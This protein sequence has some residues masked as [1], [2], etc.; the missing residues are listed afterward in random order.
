ML[1]NASQQ[2]R[3][4]D[5]SKVWGKPGWPVSPQTLPL[6]FRDGTQHHCANHPGKCVFS[7][8]FLCEG[9]NILEWFC[10]NR[11]VWAWENIMIMAAFSEL[12]L[13]L[14]NL[15]ETV[16]LMPGHAHMCRRIF[17]SWLLLIFVQSYQFLASHLDTW[18]RRTSHHIH[19]N[20]ST[21]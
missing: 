5:F 2:D 14:E 16:N 10:H 15:E 3:L 19:N 9:Q 12:L 6:V 1:I 17:P 8:C 4:C 11:G 13:L 20:S 21:K 7:M 18:I